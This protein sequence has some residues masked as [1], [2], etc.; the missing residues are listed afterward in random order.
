LERNQE[1]GEAMVEMQRQLR[2]HEGF[3]SAWAVSRAWMTNF[4]HGY[5]GYHLS[6]KDGVALPDKVFDDLFS[7]EANGDVLSDHR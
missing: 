7:L 5:R 3:S 2:E 6:G 4:R 1:V